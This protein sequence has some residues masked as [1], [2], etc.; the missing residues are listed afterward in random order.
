MTYA[1]PK[2]PYEKSALAPF[3]TEE[4]FNFHYNKHHFAYID[5]LNKLMVDTPFEKM[6]L[7]E[8][9]PKSLEAGRKDIFNNAAQA[10]NHT[11]FWY[12]MAPKAKASLGSEMKALLERDFGSVADFQTKFETTGVGQFGSGWVW[13]MR[14]AAGKLTVESTGNA[15]APFVSNPGKTPVLVCDV[16]EH[17]YYIDYRNERPRFLKSFWDNVNWQFAHDC[18][19][20]NKIFDAS[21]LMK[22]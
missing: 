20:S 1:L 4:T 16:W 19:K 22:A 21:S 14:D 17:A 7:E 18:Y 9:M 8:M 15:D 13:L 11:F 3:L 5:K 6:S 10:W 12:C 2:L